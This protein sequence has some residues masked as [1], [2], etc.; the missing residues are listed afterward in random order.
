MRRQSI[1]E[2]P[3]L[4]WRGSNIKRIKMKGLRT[5]S[6]SSRMHDEVCLAESPLA[7]NPGHGL[8]PASEPAFI[9]SD[10]EKV[11]CGSV[12]RSARDPFNCLPCFCL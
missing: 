3:R 12:S 11:M 7:E 10:A 6:G 5:L 2:H 1:A 4:F 9:V 8:T